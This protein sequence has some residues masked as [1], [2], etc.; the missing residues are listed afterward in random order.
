MRMMKRVA[1]AVAVS[2]GLTA[3]TGVMAANQGDLGATSSGD[4]DITFSNADQARIWGLEDLNLTDANASDGAAKTHD[5]CVFS[6]KSNTGS[7]QYEMEIES[8]NTFKLVNA[9]TGAADPGTSLAYTVSIADPVGN[10]FDVNVSAQTDT[11]NLYAGSLSNQP[12]PGNDDCASQSKA[13][14]S[15]SIQFVGDTTAIGNVAAGSYYDL[16]TLTVTPL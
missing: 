12:D 1:L 6:N 14:T 16:V 15:L 8:L 3:T 10:D 2:A 5:F 4:F 7:N 13:K 11:G 9:V